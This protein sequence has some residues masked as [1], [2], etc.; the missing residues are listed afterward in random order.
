ML[1]IEPYYRIRF[2]RLELVVG[3]WRNLPSR[4]PTTAKRRL[5]LLQ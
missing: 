1:W 5:S 3:H 4:A 2:C